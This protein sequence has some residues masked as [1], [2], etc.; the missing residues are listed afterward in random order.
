MTKIENI[1][2]I[3]KLMTQLEGGKKQ[4]DIAQMTEILSILSKVLV[5]RADVGTVLVNHG[6]KLLAKEK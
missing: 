6:Q 5:S 3:A 1:N 2:D 4:V